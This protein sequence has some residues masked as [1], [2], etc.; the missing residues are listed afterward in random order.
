MLSRGLYSFQFSNQISEFGPDQR[1][2]VQKAGLGQGLSS[3]RLFLGAGGWP[4]QCCPNEGV[5]NS[6]FCLPVCH[7]PSYVS[8]SPLC[9]GLS[10]Y[11]RPSGSMDFLCLVIATGFPDADAGTF[12]PFCIP[13]PHTRPLVDKRALDSAYPHITLFKSCV[14]DTD[15]PIL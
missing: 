8:S 6:P 11:S 7:G 10:L 5:R 15:A 1:A 9:Q 12:L 14:F 2:L 4:Q 13:G 3:P